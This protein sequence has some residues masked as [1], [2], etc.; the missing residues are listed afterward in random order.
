MQR[1]QRW[2]YSSIQTDVF[3]KYYTRSITA[4]ARRRL[5]RVK[6]NESGPLPE[7]DYTHLLSHPDAASGGCPALF[8]A[9]MENLADRPF[10]MAFVETIGGADEYC[11]EFLRVPAIKDHPHHVAKGIAA[12]Y[13]GWELGNT[14][15][16]VQ[17]MGSYLPVIDEIVPRLIARGAPRIDLNCGCPASKVTGK[18]AGSSLLKDPDSLHELVKH[19]VGLVAG[20]VPVSVKMRAGYHDDNLFMENAVSIQEAGATFVT[21]HPRTRS[22]GYSGHANWEL[23]SRAKQILDIPVIG[24][25]DVNT[26]DAA[27]E[28]WQLTKCDGIMIGRG[29]IQDPLIFHRIRQSLSNEQCAAPSAAFLSSEAE[30]ICSFLR[31][32]AH[33]TLL[34]S[35]DH[36]CPAPRFKQLLAYMFT[37]NPKY[38]PYL[39]RFRRQCPSRSELIQFVEEICSVVHEH[40]HD[41][42]LGQSVLINHMTLAK[43]K[44]KPIAGLSTC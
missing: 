18:G 30:H 12:T 21:I 31:A 37:W 34:T 38:E 5:R 7:V 17:I 41:G 40:H 35:D 24:N 33:Y 25:G 42:G 26:V 8:L 4:C 1:L 39:R 15:L 3:A 9:P 44:H 6:V 14:P 2:S 13:S 29:A 27:K 23:I 11:T 22:Q 43:E 20:R 32:F 36:R 10:R 16:G 28:L 19:I